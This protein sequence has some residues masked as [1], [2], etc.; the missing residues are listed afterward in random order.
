MSSN[1]GGSPARERLPA[2]YL[3]IL[4]AIRDIAPGTHL[5]AQDVFARARRQRPKLGFATVHRGLARLSEL[6]YVIKVDVPGAACA[7]YEQ[8]AEP[9]A[10]FRCSSCGSIRDIAFSLPPELLVGL[11]RQH[12]LQIEVESTTF[13]GRCASCR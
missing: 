6:G 8:T 12:D 10:H 7:V 3:T 4:A 2:N 5:T 11:A 9:H 1:F 13:T